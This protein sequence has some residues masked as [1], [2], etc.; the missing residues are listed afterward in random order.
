MS[1]PFAA[2]YHAVYQRGQL[3]GADRP[4]PA[5]PPRPTPP[6]VRPKSIAIGGALGVSIIT[7]E[8]AA[9]LVRYSASMTKAA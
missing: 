2:L 1:D 4:L 5:D 9:C 8:L 6:D 7:K 3:F